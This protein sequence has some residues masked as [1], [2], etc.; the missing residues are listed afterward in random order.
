[1]TGIM[2]MSGKYDKPMTGIGGGLVLFSLIILEIVSL[3][4]HCIGVANK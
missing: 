1:M 2:P 4:S 3:V